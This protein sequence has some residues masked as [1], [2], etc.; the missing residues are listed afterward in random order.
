[1]KIINKSIFLVFIALCGAF[2]NGI[3]VDALVIKF[4]EFFKYDFR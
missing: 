4:G 3:P 1:M 2:T